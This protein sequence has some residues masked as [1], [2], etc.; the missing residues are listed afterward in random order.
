MKTNILLVE[1]TINIAKILTYDL[2]SAGFQTTTCFTG[3]QALEQIALKNYPIYLLDWMLPD[4]SGIELCAKIRKTQPHAHIIILTAKAE[5]KDKIL[6]LNTGADDYLTKPFFTDELIARINAYLRKMPQK[7]QQIIHFSN[8]TIDTNKIEITCNK[9]LIALSKKEYEL[10]LYFVTH[11]NKLIT[12]DT[13]L[14]QIWGYNYDGQN[15]TVDVHVFKL[16]N[17]IE[18]EANIQ[19]ETIRGLGYLFSQ[20]K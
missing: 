2:N 14:E 16:R 1:D 8:L 18:T 9:T 3:K 13:L 5:Q 7:A 17:K 10:L 4:I 15:R 11:P 20:K 6:A 12:R 19:I